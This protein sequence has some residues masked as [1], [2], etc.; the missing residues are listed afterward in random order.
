MTTQPQNPAYT[1]GSDEKSAQVMIYTT[2]SLFWGDVVVKSMIRI[3]TWLR[4]NAAPDRITLYNA[5]GIVTTTQGNLRPAAYIEINIPVPQ[6]LAFHLVP[7]AKD[8][9]DYD[10]TEPNRRMD[11][12]NALFSTFQAKGSLRLSTNA[13]LKK[14]L[15]VTREA[16]TALYD[17]EITNLIIPSLGPITVPY[18]LVR[19]E[20]AVFTRR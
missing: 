1:P 10:P 8:P 17:A 2:S 14:Y 13:D 15:E 7:P 16:Y 9:L 3:S 19:Q 11:P 20:A 12:I 5:K 4:T 6:V 18:V